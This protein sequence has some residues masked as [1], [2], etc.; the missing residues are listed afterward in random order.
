LLKRHT[1]SHDIISESSGLTPSQIVIFFKNDG[2]PISA[3]AEIVKVQQKTVSAWLKEG[4]IQLHNQTR[5]ETLYHL[6]IEEKQA[7]LL[8]LYVFWNHKLSNGRSLSSLLK[9]PELQ[10]N[11]IKHALLEVWPRAQQYQQLV[12]NRDLGKNLSALQ[13]CIIQSNDDEGQQEAAKD[14][15][16]TLADGSEEW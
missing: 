16:G 12:F 6:L 4:A 14:W 2:L 7:S 10:T 15:E 13:Q 1:N 11:V 5:L 8:H 3:I 9:E